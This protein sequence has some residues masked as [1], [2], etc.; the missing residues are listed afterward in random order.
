MSTSVQT[1]TPAQ[2]RGESPEVATG[3]VHLVGSVPLANAEEVFRTVSAAL[4]DRL[5]RIP[6]GETEARLDWFVWQVTRFEA[7]P[8]LEAV[9]AAARGYR[10]L[11]KFR[12]RPG[13]DPA[14]VDF[15]RLGYAD[16]AR[17]S[18]ETFA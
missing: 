8:Q 5:R 7:C 3:G 12:L 17:A 15:G 11:P 16:A 9:P 13:V 1:S 2:S 6:D 4:G 10:T 14:S 18:Y